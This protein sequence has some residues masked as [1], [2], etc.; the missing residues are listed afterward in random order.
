MKTL[1]TLMLGLVASAASFAQSTDS[2]STDV[3][4]SSVNQ[5][6][7][8]YIAPQ[9]ATA[10]IRLFDAAGHELYNRTESAVQ[11][12]RQKLNLSEL[13]PGTYHL[14]VVKNG[15]TIN[16][17]FVIEEVPAQKQVTLEA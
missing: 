4:V 2:P 7:Q 1:I 5:R 15:Q 16:K 12:L 11:G 9:S 8:V 14:T 13:E 3:I 6:L 17:I 10:T